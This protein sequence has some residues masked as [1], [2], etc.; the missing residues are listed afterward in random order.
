[1]RL[2]LASLIC[3]IMAAP[4]FGGSAG[5]SLDD[6]GESSFFLNIS[7][8]LVPGHDF[9]HKFGEN[10]DIDTASGF[11]VIWDAG[12]D[13]VKP[14]V[15]RLHDVTS[16]DAADAGTVLSS[17]TATG[18]TTTTLVDTGATFATDGVT[19]NDLVLDDS[20]MQIGRVTSVAETTLTMLGGWREPQFGRIGPPIELG[21]SYRVVTD[22]LTG[23][24]VMHLIGLDA[25]LMD[26]QEFV[27][28]DGLSAAASATA[29]NIIFRAR[30][31]ASD[32][33]G[34]VGVISATAQTDGTISAQ[35]VNGNNQTLMAV[36]TC[37][38]DKICYI[39]RW[40][41]AISKKTAA[42]SNI[43][44]RA[45]NLSGVSYIIQNRT[46]D[47]S[48][49]SQF[50]DPFVVP[51]PVVGGTDLWVEADSDANDVGID[52]GF[53]LIIVDN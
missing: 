49:S 23:A 45:G 14:T 28:M 37:P 1:M 51:L 41:G 18:G 21:D 29:Y 11:E 26:T 2:F 16:S 43:H 19:V 39:A 50:N 36:R 9:D 27:V 4:A 32:A 34:A 31:F 48:A 42:F 15:P 24:S 52:A 12:G 13:Y 3:I 44:L 20:N 47:S 33:A 5:I 25:T 46:V 22:A 30:I 8:Q 35:I 6:R 40:W 7:Q 10:V 17:G 38:L 53:D